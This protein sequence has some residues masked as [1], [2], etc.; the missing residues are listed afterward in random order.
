MCFIN[1]IWDNI[2]KWID[3]EVGQ[4]SEGDTTPQLALKIYAKKCAKIKNS[5]NLV[6]NMFDHLEEEEHHIIQRRNL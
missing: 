1:Q 6:C 2:L 5:C 3:V 4:K